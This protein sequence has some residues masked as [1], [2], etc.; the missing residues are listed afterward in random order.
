MDGIIRYVVR[1]APCSPAVGRD[2]MFTLSA[3]RSARHPPEAALVCAG[4]YWV[5][6]DGSE[7]WDV[8]G[9][10]IT[11]QLNG[12]VKLVYVLAVYCP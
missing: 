12:Q 2:S 7:V 10:R 11:Q 8:A 5:A 3:G 1:V 4:R 6:E 9:V